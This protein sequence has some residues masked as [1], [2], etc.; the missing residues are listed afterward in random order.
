M[1][2]ALVL[3]AVPVGQREGQ[4]R[5][6]GQRGRRASCCGCGCCCGCCCRCGGG[7]EVGRR[8]VEQLLPVLTDGFDPPL[9][10]Q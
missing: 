2:A 4:G 8:G 1:A 10:L 7:R 6:G 3:A 5:G 9:H